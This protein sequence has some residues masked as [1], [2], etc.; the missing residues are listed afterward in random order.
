MQKVTQNKGTILCVVMAGSGQNV[1]DSSGHSGTDPTKVQYEVL[2]DCGETLKCKVRTDGGKTF[3]PRSAQSETE[4]RAAN[5]DVPT[6]SG[7][8]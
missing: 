6:N 2:T 5:C 8:M 4:P 1:E 7:G 3:E